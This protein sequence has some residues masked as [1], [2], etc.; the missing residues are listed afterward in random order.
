MPKSLALAHTKLAVLITSPA[1]PA[2]P[3]AAE[4]AAGISAAC[5]ILDSDFVFAATDSDKVAEKALCDANNTN[6]LSASNY[7]AGFTIFRMFN[8]GTGAPDPTT[9]AL[10]TACKTKGTTLWLYARRTGKLETA[11]WAAADEIYLGASILTDTPQA[12]D[13]G[14]YIKYRVPMEVQ[15]AYPFIAA[16]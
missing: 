11:A 4:L 12:Q 8:A 9:D 10:F 6:A 15:V 16:A 14:G 7:T 13:A 3:T 5:T 1:N 2:A